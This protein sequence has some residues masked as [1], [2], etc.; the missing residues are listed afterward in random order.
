MSVGPGFGLLA[1]VVIAV[2]VF[3][4]RINFAEAYILA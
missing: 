4:S 1:A 3:R 2:K